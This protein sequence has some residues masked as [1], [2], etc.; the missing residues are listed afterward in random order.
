[1]SQVRRLVLVILCHP[2]QPLVLLLQDGHDRWRLP[3]L[4]CG[5]GAQTGRLAAALLGRLLGWEHHWHL[6]LLGF[7]PPLAVY[8]AL[9][10]GISGVPGGG[11]WFACD[12]VG[13]V[14]ARE[15]GLIARAVQWLQHEAGFARRGIV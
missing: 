12:A 7:W 9:V 15:A 6:W 1:M 4:V 2:G 5:Q 3:A 11:W 8:L 10:D 13:L 14:P